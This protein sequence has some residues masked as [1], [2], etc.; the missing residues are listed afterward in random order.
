MIFIKYI[1]TLF[2]IVCN[3]IIT[4]AYLFMMDNMSINFF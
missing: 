4:T 3:Q 2:F 1:C